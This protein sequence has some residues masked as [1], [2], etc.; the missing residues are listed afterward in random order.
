LDRKKY[1]EGLIFGSLAYGLWGMLPLY[2]KLVSAI[3]PYQIFAQRVVWSFLFITVL[4]IFK[5]NYR[6][7]IRVVTNFDQLKKILPP[8][9]FISVNW[10]LYI[11]AVNNNFVL[12]T[13][14][15]YYITPL[16]LTILGRLF[17]KERLNNYQK[18]GIGLATLGVIFKTILYGKLPLI[19]LVLA[20]SFAMYGFYK[21][22]SGLDS[23]TGLGFET[24]IIGIPSLMYLL[25]VET[26]GQGITGNLP[27]VYWIMIAF[28]G[29]IT[30]T[31]LLLY[32]ES[33]KRLPL[34]VVG[35]LQY[36]SPTIAL[37][38][39][40]FVFKETF[41]LRSFFSFALIWIGLGFFSY[42]QYDL[43]KQSKLEMIGE[44]DGHGK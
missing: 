36:L 13:S 41:D 11:W 33:T 16:I 17:Y 35:F 26:S 20:L 8:T 37:L 3:S 38:L 39:A 25:F 28:S 32:A 24:F 34:N 1:I 43:L 19:S 4:L 29:L 14:L 10:M 7:F 5:R 9:L 31:P 44:R 23:L 2:W 12:E 6:A 15:G 27:F 40:I 22:K 21:K 30:A 42:S 18:I